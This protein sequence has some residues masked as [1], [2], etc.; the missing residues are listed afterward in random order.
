MAKSRKKPAGISK[1]IG[2]QGNDELPRGA[3]VAIRDKGD[4]DAAGVIREFLR[5]N[6]RAGKVLLGGLA[7]VAA[8]ALVQTWK[9]DAQ[10]ALI[11]GAQIAVLGGLLYIIT[12]AV[13]DKALKKVMAWFGVLFMMTFSAVFFYAAVVPN[14]TLVKPAYCLVRFWDRCEDVGDAVADRNY[15]PPPTTAARPS[16]IQP[17][18]FDQYRVSV[19]FAGIIRR[20]DMVAATTKLA[21]DGWN[22]SRPERG[23]ERTPRAAGRNEIRYYSASDEPAAQSLA[24]STQNLNIVASTIRVAL[25]PSLP[26]GTLEMWISR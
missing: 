25:T 5:Q 24:S 14:P 6:P 18:K 21:G 11:M 20:N 3:P 1:N 22:V 17:V 19:Y 2:G 23:G 8:A 4:L 26:P 7:V 10:S 13:H 9:I 12:F 15:T 16:P